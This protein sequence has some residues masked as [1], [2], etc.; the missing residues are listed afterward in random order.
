MLQ[1]GAI[2]DVNYVYCVN[3]FS[4]IR[5]SDC[6]NPEDYANMNRY[7]FIVLHDETGIFT[8]SLFL[9]NLFRQVY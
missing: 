2:W 3:K 8:A 9:S 7:G 6:N 4:A 1:S 5:K